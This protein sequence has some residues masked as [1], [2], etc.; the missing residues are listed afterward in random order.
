M[1]T[2]KPQLKTRKPKLTKKQKGFAK[3]YAITENGTEAALKNYDIK[4]KKPER[5]AAAI[6]SENLTVPSIVE[7]IDNKRKSLKQALIDKGIDENKIA[8][9][10]DVLL[11]AKKPIWEEVD[12]QMEH[13][14]D[15]IDFTAVDKGLKHATAI[16]GITPEG[17]RPPIS[18][19][20]NFLFSKETQ[21]RIKIIN[22]EIKNKLINVEPD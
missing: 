13:V 15:E 19:T 7:E 22:E 10:V 5:I 3:D 21:E 16:F 11:E 1:T 12:G 20:Y 2:E 14:G 6:A 18:V 17:N 4:G 8:E 9:K